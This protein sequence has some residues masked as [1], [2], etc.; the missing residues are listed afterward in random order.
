MFLNCSYPA[1]NIDDRDGVEQTTP[2]VSPSVEIGKEGWE[3]EGIRK[4]KSW[5]ANVAGCRAEC[6]EKEA[7]HSTEA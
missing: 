6:A 3:S 4:L 7:G 1:S 2:A 5:Y